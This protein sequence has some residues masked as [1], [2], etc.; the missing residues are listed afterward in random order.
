MHG[1]YSECYTP[2]TH[3]EI[4]LENGQRVYFEP[5]YAQNAIKKNKEKKLR[6][7]VPFKMTKKRWEVM[8]KWLWVLFI[9]GV[10]KSVKSIFE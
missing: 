8:S 6:S 2:I 1:F 9:K 5:K 7:Q 3:L 10:I 4:H